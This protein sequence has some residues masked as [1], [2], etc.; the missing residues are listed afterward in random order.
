MTGES[1]CDCRLC[2]RSRKIHEIVKARDFDALKAM[3]NDVLWELEAAETELEF[4]GRPMH[5]PLVLSRAEIKPASENR[6]V[7]DG[8]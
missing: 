3:L 6:E 8:E 1:R 4:Q 2:Q 5:E 7:P